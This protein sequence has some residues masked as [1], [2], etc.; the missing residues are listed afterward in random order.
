MLR[1]QLIEGL[2]VV[3]EPRS[4]E[5]TKYNKKTGSLKLKPVSD[6]TDTVTDESGHSCDE[7]S[8][9]SSAVARHIVEVRSILKVTQP[10]SVNAKICDA[11][12]NKK[13]CVRFRSKNMATVYHVEPYLKYSSELWWNENEITDRKCSQESKV[14]QASSSEYLRAMIKGRSQVVDRTNSKS[15]SLLSKELFKE[16]VGGRS[17]GLAGLEQYSSLYSECRDKKQRVVPATVRKYLELRASKDSN[18]AE[19]IGSYARSLSSADRS[20][21]FIL[22]N[23]DTESIV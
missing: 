15:K 23:A 13:V 16:I 21:A 9:S 12:L 10:T 19:S 2:L 6:D 3:P 11:L 14:M 17:Q 4:I 8:S 7:S 22:G 5:K 1:A 18:I 20:W